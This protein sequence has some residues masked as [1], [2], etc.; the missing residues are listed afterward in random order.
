MPT[1]WSF[2]SKGGFLI[3]PIIGGSIIA[4]AVFIERLFS[5]RREK[6]LPQKFYNQLLNLFFRKKWDEAVLLCR[7]ENHP[8]SRIVLA[9]LNAYENNAPD[10][11]IKEVAEEAGQREVFYIE[12]YTGIIGVIASIEPLLGLLGTVLGM[13]EAF[14]QVEVGGV[15]D[16]R[17]VAAGVWTALIT[18]AL[19]LAVAIPSYIAY[20]YLLNRTDA[21]ILEL[22]EATSNLLDILLSLKN[23]SESLDLELPQP[24]A[25]NNTIHPQK[26]PNS[27][28]NILSEGEQIK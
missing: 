28:Q 25:T 26:L 27:D 11:R 7:K 18:T 24:I 5:L 20:R 3:Y 8:L 21:L 10:F 15:G 17:L 12:R 9:F 22:Q 19:G 23:Q 2:L 6:L 13:I 14:R 1:M 4:V 16:P